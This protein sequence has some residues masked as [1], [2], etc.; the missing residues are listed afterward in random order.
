MTKTKYSP[1]EN[2]YIQLDISF[3]TAYGVNEALLFDKLYRLQ[4]QFEGKVDDKGNK[5]V[6]LTYDEWENEV[7]F[8]SRNT[9]IRTIEHLEETGIFLSII[10]AGRSKWYRCNPDYVQSHL[11]KMGKSS[12][13]NGQL[14]NSSPNSSLIFDEEEIQAGKY[15][16]QQIAFGYLAKVCKIDLGLLSKKQEGQLGRES[17]RLIKAGVD[18]PEIERFGEWWYKND[19]RG[20][21]GQPP[22]PSQVS[23]N[24]GQ[25][26]EAN[27]RKVVISAK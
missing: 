5:W 21:K 26:R 3:A 15:T 7:P 14:P 9:I 2:H 18:P 10:F 25:F 11:P 6:R 20:Q 19:W 12:T 27:S 23:E 8:L 4:D 22:G 24:W 17:S 16:P 1:P 13:Q